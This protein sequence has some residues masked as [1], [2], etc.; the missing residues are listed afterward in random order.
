LFFALSF[1]LLAF[2]LRFLLTLMALRVADKAPSVEQFK[3]WQAQN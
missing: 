1:R 2:V 3:G